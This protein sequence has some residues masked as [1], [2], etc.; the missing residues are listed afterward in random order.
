MKKTIKILICLIVFISCDKAFIN[1]E[2]DGM[3]KLQ[4]IECGEE[5]Q[6]TTD[7]YYSFQRHMVQIS[8]HYEEETPLRYIGNLKHKNDT[9]IINGFRKFLEEDIIATP[10][11][12]KKFYLYS[13]SVIFNIE[14]LN[15]E[16]LVMQ[17]NNRR[18]IF[19]KW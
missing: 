15:E 18:Y 4:Q 5:T 16:T 10:D 12:L 11:I 13:D 9:I 14:K 19:R 2:L 6:K 3:W 7:I 1:D 8:K 17:N